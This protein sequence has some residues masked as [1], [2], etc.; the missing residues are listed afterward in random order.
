M[1]YLNLNLGSLKD[2]NGKFQSKFDEKEYSKRY[3]CQNYDIFETS[4]YIY[5]YI[6]V[7]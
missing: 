4:V 3:N 6:Y 7:E 1:K 5:I 2:E